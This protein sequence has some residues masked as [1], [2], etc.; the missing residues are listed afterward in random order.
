MLDY[1]SVVAIMEY[2]SRKTLD[3]WLND[4]GYYRKHI[5]LDE[6]CL[7]RAVS[8]RSSK[9]TLHT[10]IICVHICHRICRFIIHKCTMKKL[11]IDALLML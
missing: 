6:T 1:Q 8:D 9:Y 2:K 10:V 5:A 7:F 4:K 11:E 3:N